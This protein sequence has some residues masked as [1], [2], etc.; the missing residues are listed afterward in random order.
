[1]AYQMHIPILESSSNNSDCLYLLALLNIVLDHVVKGDFTGEL[2]AQHLVNAT[3]PM[4]L[5]DLHVETYGAILNYY[6]VLRE[7]NEGLRDV[8][9]LLRSIQAGFLSIERYASRTR[10]CS[11]NIE[12]ANALQVYVNMKLSTLKK[13]TYQLI[14]LQYGAQIREHYS[15]SPLK[16]L[17]S[18]GEVI[19]LTASKNIQLDTVELYTWPSLVRICW[20]KPSK[21]NETHYVFRLEIPSA[22][23]IESLGLKLRDVQQ[24]LLALYLRFINNSYVLAEFIR[25]QYEPPRVQLDSPGVIIKGSPLNVTIISNKFYNASLY[26]NDFEVATMLLKPGLTNLTVDYSSLNYTIGLNRVKLCVNATTETFSQCFDRPVYIELLYPRV[27]VIA[28]S[29][30]IAWLGYTKLLVSNEDQEGLYVT[31]TNYGK[32]T[33]YVSSGEVRE[34]PIYGGPLPIQSVNIK[35]NVEPLDKSYSTLDLDLSIYVV[36]MPVVI[37]LIFISVFIT[38]LISGYEQSFI[39]TIAS[40]WRRVQQAP[41]RAEEF[42]KSA[43]LKPYELGLNSRIALLYYGL[44]KKLK[45]RLPLFNET[46]REHYIDTL[47]YLPEKLRGILWKFL[48]LVEKDL[49]SSKKPAYQEAETMYR[50]VSRVASEE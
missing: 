46:L 30:S 15:I 47:H 1:M 33:I 37:A 2:M 27:R 11:H 25:V 23:L 36:N 8:T 22:S 3:V 42:L 18:P 24:D 19:E 20:F 41:H 40:V 28:E 48:M 49:Y 45:L 4:E 44:L 14:E 34:M 12:A 6:R 16:D 35:V 38:V 9:P 43:I 50:G 13:Y 39:L 31:V 29:I 26:F 17:Y 32:R 10:A 21:F 5:R 7:V